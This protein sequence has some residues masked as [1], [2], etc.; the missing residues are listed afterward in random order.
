MEKCLE[1]STIEKKKIVDFIT[2]FE[3][4]EAKKCDKDTL[5]K[6]E[7]HIVLNLNLESI[8]AL[9]FSFFL[10]KGNITAPF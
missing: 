10:K 5:K 9:A 2:S 4:V 6:W 3:N 1:F 8:Y 7:K